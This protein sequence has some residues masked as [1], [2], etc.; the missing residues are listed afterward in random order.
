LAHFLTDA[1]VGAAV[2]RSTTASRLLRP[3][4]LASHE[5]RRGVGEVGHVA[6]DSS[7][8]VLVFRGLLE[9]SHAAPL[10]GGLDAVGRAGWE[11]DDLHSV[12]DNRI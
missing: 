3:N 9:V 1:S 6:H 5:L 4:D 7:H 12:S 11:L 8:G 10:E 2:H